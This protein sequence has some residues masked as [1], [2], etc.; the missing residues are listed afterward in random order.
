MSLLVFGHKNPDTD[1]I[2]S[3]VS[4]AYLK[5]QLGQDATAY[6]LGEIRKEAKYALD[7]FKV[8]PPQILNNVKVQVKDLSYSKVS[9]LTPKASVL[10]AYNLMDQKDVKTLPVVSEEDEFIGIVTMKEVAKSLLNQHFTSVHTSLSNIC[11][12]LSGSL[13]VNCDEEVNGRVVT[14][15]FDMQTLKDVLKEGDIVIVGDRFDTI[16][17]AINTKVKVLI[18]TGKTKISDSLLNLAKENGVSVISVDCDTYKA[19]NLIN[20][21]NFLES[22]LTK[23]NLIVFNENDYVDDIKEVM[24]NHNFRFYPIVDKDNKFLG[25]VSKGHLLNPTRKNVVLVDHNEY[26]QSADGIEQ[27]N[28]V[29]VIDHHKLGGI[30]TDVPL[31]FRIMP[32]GCSCTVIYNMYKENNVEV[33]YEIAGLLLSAILSDTLLFKSPTTTELDKKACEEL[34]KIAKVDMEK[35]AMDMFKCGTSLDEFSI[36]QIVNM[37]FKEFNMSGKRVGIGQV[38]TLDIDSIFAKKDEFLSY[39]NSTDYDILILAITDIIKEG[40]YLIYKAPDNVISSAFNVD[41]SQGVFAEGVVSRKKQL[42]PNLTTAVKN[43]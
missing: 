33:P 42:V 37:D 18:L 6:A 2:C 38:F 22:I 29:E 23:E 30:S 40:S 35:Y 34:S 21:C 1:S 9:P 24:L 15:S 28:I 4:L 32:V 20:Q 41:A 8:D 16:E 5:R 25:L 3:S 26:A 17:Y 19:S 36:E 43:I 31:S 27:A 13:L 12:N 39:I 11:K 10:E 14:L 7:Y